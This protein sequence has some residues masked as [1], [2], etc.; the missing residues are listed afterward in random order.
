MYKLGRKSVMDMGLNFSLCPFQVRSP[1]RSAELVIVLTV[2]W[3]HCW[4][5]HCRSCKWINNLPFNRQKNEVYCKKC[6]N[7]LIPVFSVC[8][9]R[10]IIWSSHSFQTTTKGSSGSDLVQTPF[11]LSSVRLVQLWLHPSK[12]WKS[13]RWAL[14]TSETCSM[15]Y[16]VA[17]KETFTYVLS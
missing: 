1:L 9:N 3:I 10:S 11:H 14:F 17:S 2:L 4:C 15:L 7:K 5:Q 13:S 12:S 8:L 16:Y 6:I